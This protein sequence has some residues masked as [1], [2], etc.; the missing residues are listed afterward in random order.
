MLM[1]ADFELAFLH[2][3]HHNKSQKEL[4]RPSY[5]F[6]GQDV[7]NKLLSIAFWVF[8]CLTNETIDRE[9][10]TRCPGQD[11]QHKLPP[12]A[13]RK[14]VQA[15]R[16]FAGHQDRTSQNGV[17]IIFHISR[18]RLHNTKKLKLSNCLFQQ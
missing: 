10:F 4:V 14:P 6:P 9:R 18:E 3:P 15:C 13:S 16:R 17:S 7:Y 11:F 2:V 1:H 8:F 5:S 12:T